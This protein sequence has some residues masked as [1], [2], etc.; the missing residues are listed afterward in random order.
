MAVN[1]CKAKQLT[2]MRSKA[3]DGVI[4]LTPPTKFSLEQCLDFLA[5]D[6]LLEITPLSLHLRKKHLTALE[7]KRVNRKSQDVY[8]SLVNSKN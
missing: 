6:E 8:F 2:N 3:S 5:D 4:Q 7:R 1:V